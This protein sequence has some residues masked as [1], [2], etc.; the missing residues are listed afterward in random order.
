MFQWLKN[1][2]TR[3][4]VKLCCTKIHT[5][6][7][8]THKNE[9]LWRND[10]FLQ[11]FGNKIVS[12]EQLHIKNADNSFYTSVANKDFQLNHTKILNN[13][14]I[15]FYPL[16]E[17]NYKWW[18]TIPLPI[19]LCNKNYEIED[20]NSYF[21]KLI[22]NR[23]C[24]IKHYATQFNFEKTTS[25]QGQEL[26]WNSTCGIVPIQTWTKKYG[27]DILII[28]ESRLE[29]IRLKNQAQEGQHLQIL[30]Q[31]TSG[32]IHDFN[33]LLTAING[34]AEMLETDLP[35]N[36][37]LLEI[38]RNTGLAAN[39]AKE[40]LNFVKQ[41]PE[42]KG[43]T[44]LCVFL[45][46]RQRMLQKL[47]G[48][49]IKLEIIAN[50]TGCVNLSET[51][52]EQII[53]NMVI[54]G[55][56]AMQ[57]EGELRIIVEKIKLRHKTQIHNC[58]SLNKGEYFSLI[59]ADTGSG[60]PVEHINKI[61]SPFFSTKINGTGLGLAS[62]MRIMQH[63]NGA[64]SL[65]TSSRGTQFTLYLPISKETLQQQMASTQITKPVIEKRL[66]LVEDEESIRNLV[67]QALQ[68]AGYKV[69]TF[70]NGLDAFNNININTEIDCLISDAILPGMDGTTL[71]TRV[72]EI[73]PTLPIII[74]SGYSFEDLKK[75]LPENVHY[76]PKPFTLK[77]M[78]EK[79]Q[80][81]FN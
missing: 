32:I 46:S 68:F 69:V 53:L 19:A 56:D 13:F 25:E 31:L 3:F 59:I 16:K 10:A 75:Y 28:L 58:A 49:K 54:N 43:I 6:I 8:L 39:L 51:Q 34:F 66:F 5:P 38:K 52:L 72:R 80:E 63:S 18:K 77:S 62:C 45:T 67:S 15:T 44:E 7:C 30:G 78:K 26:I 27:D 65:K 61:F 48:E 76:L 4:V 57:G 42:E 40:L 1:F 17:I 2:T 35:D 81:I 36:A 79:L 22:G 50:E 9:I 14:I 73:R 29:F 70:A 33:N 12:F 24:Q 74:V 64:I 21:R 41:K 71:A 20:V 55:R 11:L 37:M 47:L 23:K 60:I